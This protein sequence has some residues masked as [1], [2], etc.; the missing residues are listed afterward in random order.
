MKIKIPSFP[1]KRQ[2][3]R[4]KILDPQICHVQVPQ[5][6]NFWEDQG[7]IRNVC[8]DGI[9][10]ICD[11]Q[12]PLE[13]DEINNLTFDIFYNDH[14][15][16]RLKFHGL[17]VRTEGKQPDRSQVAIALKFLSDPIYVP[18]K[19]INYREFPFFDKIRILFQ[20]YQLNKKAH[21]IIK[22]MPDIRE[23]KITSIKERIDQG[24][25]KIEPDKMAQNFTDNLLK[26][27]LLISKR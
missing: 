17:V 2:F 15:I 26:E 20:Y 5:S 21:E 7:I 1:E 18:L 19:E 8:L 6:Q 16:Y 14:K 12:P 23:D 13:K 10:F 22:R 25:Y 4:V 27:K 3:G 24:L 11:S 9:Y